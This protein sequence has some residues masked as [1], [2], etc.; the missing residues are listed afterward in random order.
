MLAI[1]SFF[2]FADGGKGSRERT[3]KGKGL[4]LVFLIEMARFS[5]LSLSFLF[6]LFCSVVLEGNG[7][8]IS[9]FWPE[10]PLKVWIWVQNVGGVKK[11]IIDL[12]STC[13]RSAFSFAAFFDENLSE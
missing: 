12:S 3:D 11:E 1:G 9:K 10:R 2:L 7:G 4:A 5:S 13:R 6:Y 8:V